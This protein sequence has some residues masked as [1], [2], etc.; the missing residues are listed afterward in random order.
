MPE[1]PLGEERKHISDFPEGLRATLQNL[2]KRGLVEK[3]VTE[4]ETTQK[5]YGKR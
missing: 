3:R 5:V 4:E 1:L 2:V